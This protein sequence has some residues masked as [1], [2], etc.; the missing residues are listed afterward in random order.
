MAPSSLLGRIES[1][2]IEEALEKQPLLVH[3]L[4]AMHRCHLSMDVNLC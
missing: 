2:T 4:V 3:C 1:T